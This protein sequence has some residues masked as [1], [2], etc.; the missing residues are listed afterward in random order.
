MA[1]TK[2]LPG[3]YVIELFGGYR[4]LAELLHCD[5][6]TVWRFQPWP[7]HKPRYNKAGNIPLRWH[8]KLLDL[9]AKHDKK[10]SIEDIVYGR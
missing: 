6:T 7:I 5:P 1:S 10:L 9:A 8:R 3:E 2:K 4:P